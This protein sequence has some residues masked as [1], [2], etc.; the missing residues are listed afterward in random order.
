MYVV[1]NKDHIHHLLNESKKVKCFLHLRS[2]GVL[3]NIF[4]FFT[5]DND[6]CCEFTI[7][8]CT[9]R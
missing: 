4:I 7:L 5:K 9:N 8:I 1:Y 2:E 6:L 3:D